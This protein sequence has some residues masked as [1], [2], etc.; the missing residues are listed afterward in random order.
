MVDWISVCSDAAGDVV[1]W[2]AA[3]TV[4]D[5]DLI[6]FEVTSTDDVCPRDVTCDATAVADESK[7]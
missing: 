3:E 7:K 4:T 2:S 5:D 6:V 1:S